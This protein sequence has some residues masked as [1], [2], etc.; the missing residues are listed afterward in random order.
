MYIGVD[1]SDVERWRHIIEAY[2]EKVKRIFTEEEISHAE[3]RGRYRAQSYAGL[4]AAR[5]AVAKALEVGIFMTSLQEVHVTWTAEGAP[6][7]VLE[8]RY[9]KVAKEK[10]VSRIHI[11]ISHEKRMALAFVMMEVTL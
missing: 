2:P 9:Q 10:K 7:V 3:A 1:L 8:G 5:E 4:W 11:S 6:Q